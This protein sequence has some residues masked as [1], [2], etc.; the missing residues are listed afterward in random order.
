MFNDIFTQTNRLRKKTEKRLEE[1]EKPSLNFFVLIT[2][3]AGLASLGLLLN[4]TAV[5]IGAMVVA[6]LVT[7]I[8]GFSLAV[9]IMRYRRMAL[10]LL[11]IS[12]GTL[13]AIAMSILIGMI[14]LFIEGK[15]VI[16]TN[17]IL[18]RAKPNLLYFLV[19]L[20]SG[21]AGAYAYSKPKVLESVTGIAISVAIVPP[22]S[23]VGLGFAMQDWTLMQQS[24]IL[25]IL[26][27]FGI[28]F[29]SIIMFLFLGFGK[30]K[31]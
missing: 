9:I 3:S 24:F 18:D 17:E 5:I 16:L 19:A 26:N 12:L 6:P 2:L 23:V 10:S 28:C 1:Y 7:P 27:L 22:L 8:F 13:L 25:Y 15:D 31:K 21:L 11:S 4:N 29:G 20:F 30:I 14:V